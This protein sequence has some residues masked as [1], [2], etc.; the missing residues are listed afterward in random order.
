MIRILLI[1]D[2]PAL[3]TGIKMNLEY[4]GY[5][6]TWARDLKT[7]HKENAE[8][9]FDLA[10]LDLGL[11]DGNGLSF[12]T[13]A[14]DA[15][16]RMPIIILTAQA[17]EE[18]VVAGLMAGANDYIRKPFGNR[19]L[20]ARIITVLREPKVREDQA[21]FDNLVVL[22]SQRKVMF[23]PQEIDL[24]RREFDLLS[25]LV[26]NGDTVVT[27]ERLMNTLDKD[28]EILDRTMDS[29]LSHIRAKLRKAGVN[30]VQI[31]SVYG[32]G[33]RLERA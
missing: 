25:V 6:V 11:P 33:Y 31:I 3:G 15:G 1:E 28:G 32:I 14:R 8:A 2:D 13:A 12:C 10:I 30:S 29:H 26:E 18:S 9:N 20:I 22:R 23:G 16:S 27:R 19:E 17:D 21:R 7:A 24:S 5:H 4:E